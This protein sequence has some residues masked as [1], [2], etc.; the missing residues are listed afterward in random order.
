MCDSSEILVS[1]STARVAIDKKIL[2]Q[3]YL[4]PVSEVTSR[5]LDEIH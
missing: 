4:H 2:L 1:S 3:F 5:E